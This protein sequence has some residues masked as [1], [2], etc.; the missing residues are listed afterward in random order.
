MNPAL[1]RK[2]I[3][4]VAALFGAG[5]LPAQSGEP[6]EPLPT[7]DKANF[8]PDW[9]DSAAREGLWKLFVAAEQE[10]KTFAETSERWVA[11]KKAETA[12]NGVKWLSSGK[13]ELNWHGHP[14]TMFHEIFHTVCHKSRFH[15]QPEDE[16]WIEGFCDAFRYFMEKKLLKSQ[17]P[18]PWLQKMETY[19]S[20]T[21]QQMLKFN[22]GDVAYNKKYLFPAAMIISHSKKDYGEFRKLWFDLLKK[23]AAARGNVLNDFFGY[24]KQKGELLPGR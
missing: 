22:T 20:L 5:A 19:S 9:P 11:I 18:S 21:A 10:A 13:I 4:L 8:L 2:L 7:M 24:D 14:G 12:K 6:P 15:E 23:R 16:G 17:P 3:A 1:T